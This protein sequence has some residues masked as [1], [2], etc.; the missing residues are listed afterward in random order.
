MNSFSR[1]GRCSWRS[2]AEYSVHMAVWFNRSCVNAALSH[3]LRRRSIE[4]LRSAVQDV[5]GT[6]SS[7]FTR[8]VNSGSSVRRFFRRVG[9]AAH[10]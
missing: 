8:S 9:A 7:A 3:V 10:L 6:L 5:A 2:S 4:K 1:S